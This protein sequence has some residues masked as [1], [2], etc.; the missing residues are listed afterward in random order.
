[1]HLLVALI[2][3]WKLGKPVF[4]HFDVILIFSLLLS[5]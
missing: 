1:M 5:Q 4:S 2:I 3:L